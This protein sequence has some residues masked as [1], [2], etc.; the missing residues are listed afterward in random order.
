MPKKPSPTLIKKHRIYTVW[1]A[2][3][4]LGVH[5]QT[6]IRWIKD[7]GLIADKSGRLWLI[8]GSD[9]K[10]FLGERRAGGKCKLSPH[11]LYCFGCK[12]PQMPVGR[13]ADY[14]HQSQ[15]TGML[16][17]LCPC[18]GTQLNKAVRR[19]ELEVIRAKIDVTVQQADPTLV[20]LEEPPLTVTLNQGANSD[21]KT[22][23]K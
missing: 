7:K 13:M 17:G 23:V 15:T 21:V 6:V 16:T 14:K 5:R 4:A 22:H 3:D 1:E 8:K 10:H 18:C 11:H 2:G 12:S 20:P 19:S 9:L